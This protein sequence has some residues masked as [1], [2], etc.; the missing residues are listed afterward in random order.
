MGDDEDI[1][2]F[3]MK[4]RRETS[5]VRIGNVNIESKWYMMKNTGTTID[6]SL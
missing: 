1:L 6:S 3:M 5:C 4:K 2:N